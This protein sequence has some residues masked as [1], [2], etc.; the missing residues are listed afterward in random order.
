MHLSMPIQTHVG[1]VLPSGEQAQ[2]RLPSEVTK[3][4][5]SPLLHT[6]TACLPPP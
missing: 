1:C 6:L 2:V 5:L 3:A 4:V